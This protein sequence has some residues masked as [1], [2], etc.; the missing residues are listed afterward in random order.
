MKA[1]A[2]C[3][4][5]STA[6][7]TIAAANIDI[8]DPLFNED[9]TWDYI[10]I[11]ADDEGFLEQ[12]DRLAEWKR[13]KG[14]K[15]LVATVD[16]IENVVEGFDRAHKIRNFLKHAWEEWGIVWVLLLGDYDIIP[17]RH[18]S[19]GG[20]YFPYDEEEARS[21]VYYSCLEGEWDTDG[22]SVYGNEESRTEFR[23]EC[24]YDDEGSFVCEKKEPKIT[25]LDLWYDIYLGRLPASTVEEAEVMITK[26][27]EYPLKPRPEEH[28]DDMTFCAAQLHYLWTDFVTSLEMD[29]A[30]YYWHHKVKPIFEKETS[31][32]KSATID[33]L[34]EDR[35][36]DNGTVVND[37][38]E[39]TIDEMREH[40]SRGYNMVF[41]SF[42]G[43]PAGIQIYSKAA[44][45]GTP[46]F[47][48]K[49]A[50]EIESEYYSHFISIS[51]LVMKM[52][53]DTSTCFAKSLLTNPR[54]G[55][56][57]YT[58]SSGIDYFNIRGRHYKKAVD[59]LNNKGVH[60]IA[61]AWYLANVMEF[62]RHNVL[63]QQHW[64]DPELECWSNSADETEN[65]EIQTERTG[66]K[67]NVT[68]WPAIDSVLVC[69][70][71]K[72]ALFMR[73]YTI[74]GTVEFEGIDASMGGITL[75]ATKHNFVPT[76]K[77]LRA[78]D[79]VEIASAK[80]NIQAAQMNIVQINSRTA[81]HFS[82]CKSSLDARLLTASGRTIDH[83]STRESNKIWDIAALPGGVYMVKARMDGGTLIRKFLVR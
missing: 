21:D 40:L 79:M 59:L 19:T 29:D 68:V 76:Q 24:G 33:E 52:M 12:A 56:V 4:L 30:S 81:I 37:S 26:V 72:D 60:R 63:V 36:L 77:V 6:F 74:G 23:L 34:F 1:M 48:Y 32:F 78:N 57:S 35:V 5:I 80:E 28:H 75:T 58:G 2:K 69:A 18:V 10:I 83:I 46:I 11:T 39:I 71:K 14:L 66:N 51:C 64:G 13:Q 20:L 45:V 82:H 16:S 49:H 25:G 17:A 67:V 54:G 8:S 53:H 47:D 55:A 3:A 7:C 62:S 73:G 41:F 38:D 65:F 70:Y 61:K 42:H 43:N 27:L 44:E 50:H 9:A 31:K 15:T 22:D